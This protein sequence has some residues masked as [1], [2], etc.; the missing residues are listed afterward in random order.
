MQLC[1]I[2]G[3]INCYYEKL[4]PAAGNA[5]SGGLTLRILGIDPGYAI[6]GYGVLD[7]VHGKFSVVGYGA[8]TT[9]AGMDFSARLRSIYLD[10]T[11]IIEKSQP[12]ERGIEKLFFNTNEKKAIDVANELHKKFNDIKNI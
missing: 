12:D 11:Q 5:S 4:Y 1:E 2:C 3:I 8:V 9:P 10:M 7:Y 6:V